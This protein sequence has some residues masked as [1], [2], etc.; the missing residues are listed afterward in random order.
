LFRRKKA[1]PDPVT[2]MAHQ[3]TQG[4]QRLREVGGTS[5]RRGPELQWEA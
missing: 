4:L 5:C 3:V 2:I 1:G